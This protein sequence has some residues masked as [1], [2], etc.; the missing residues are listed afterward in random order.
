MRLHH[1]VER[2][3]FWVALLLGILTIVG[4]SAWVKP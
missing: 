1:R 4:V 3:L 2:Y